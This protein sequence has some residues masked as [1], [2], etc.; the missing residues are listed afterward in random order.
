MG[1]LKQ[2][3]IE[4][5]DGARALQQLCDDMHKPFA[6][7]IETDPDPYGVIEDE[8]NQDHANDNRI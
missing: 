1:Q 7:M 2:L 6:G 8:I 3:M 4:I 5:E